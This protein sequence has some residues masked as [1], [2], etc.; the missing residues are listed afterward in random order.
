M[1]SS[2]T[3]RCLSGYVKRPL[4]SDTIKCLETSQWSDLPEFCGRKNFTFS[5]AS[6]LA[7]PTA[8]ANTYCFCNCC[9]KDFPIRSDRR[10]S[11]WPENLF[12]SLLVNPAWSIEAV[13]W[14]SHVRKGR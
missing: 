2:V 13:C 4:L 7:I 5:A 8:C 12:P 10:C 11:C 1:G 6:C 3:Y 14:H 9:L